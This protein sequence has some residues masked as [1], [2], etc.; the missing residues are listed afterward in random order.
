MLSMEQ[1]AEALRVTRMG[2]PSPWWLPLLHIGKCHS[3]ALGELSSGPGLRSQMCSSCGALVEEVR[4]FLR[5]QDQ[6]WTQD[7]LEGPGMVAYS[8]SWPF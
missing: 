3:C 2:H 6:G 7:S 5:S 8:L 4:A 1:Q